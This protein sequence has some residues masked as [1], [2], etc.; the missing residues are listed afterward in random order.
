MAAN[1]VHNS[2][3]R[4]I[5]AEER[6]KLI[7]EAAYYRA[8][9]R[10]FQGSDPLEDWL[11]AEKE[12]D[13]RYELLPYEDRLE[14]LYER[15]ARANEKLRE[16]AGALRREA[17]GFQAQ[18]LEKAHKLRNAFCERLTAIRELSGRAEERARHEAEARWRDLVEIMTHLGARPDD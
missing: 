2:D 4:G 7:A 14:L 13:A 18:E 16:L 17:V 1:P 5:S 10:G 6:R 15:L 12:I 3:K 9:E 11:K 8:L